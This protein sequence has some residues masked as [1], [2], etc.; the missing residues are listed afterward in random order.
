[1]FAIAVFYYQGLLKK[2]MNAMTQPP[3]SLRMPEEI[4]TQEMNNGELIYLVFH[5]DSWNCPLP[6]ANNN[7]FA[8]IRP[9]LLGRSLKEGFKA[10]EVKK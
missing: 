7:E 4:K 2:S 5:D 9:V 6:S 1:M 8:T 10:S 3:L